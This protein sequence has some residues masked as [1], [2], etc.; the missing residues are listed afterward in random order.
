MSD[1]RPNRI[2][3][4]SGNYIEKQYIKVEGD[5]Y[6]GRGQDA[7]A[8]RTP[9]LETATDAE[10]VDEEEDLIAPDVVLPFPLNMAKARPVIMKCIRMG[11]LDN[12]VKPMGQTNTEIAVFV[13]R[14]NEYL[15]CKRTWKPYGDFWGISNLCGY[16]DRATLQ[17]NF[18]IVKGK[19]EELFEDL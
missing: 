7:Y 14:L 2:F 1:D 11:F 4:I 12:E 16:Y 6:M 18:T 15:G 5:F 8:C 9:Q 3:N 13:D 19:I 10:L 17:T